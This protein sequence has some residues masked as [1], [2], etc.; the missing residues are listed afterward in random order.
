M[1][2]IKKAAVCCT[3]SL[4]AGASVFA[5]CGPSG[6]GSFKYPDFPTTSSDK[7]SWE[8]IDEEFTIDWYVGINGFTD[9][10]WGSNS[11]SRRIQQKLGVNPFANC[12][13]R[14]GYTNRTGRMVTIIAA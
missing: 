12:F 9:F 11:T 8:Y 6:S 13:C 7:N 2:K 1:N 10:T 3:L 14:K 4:I 5:G